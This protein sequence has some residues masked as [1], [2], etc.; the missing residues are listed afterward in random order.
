MTVKEKYA[1][2]EYEEMYSEFS[3]YLEEMFPRYYMRS[4]IVCF[5]P[6]LACCGVYNASDWYDISA[7]PGQNWVPQSCCI[8]PYMNCEKSENPND[9]HSKV[10]A[11]SLLPNLVKN[12]RNTL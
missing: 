3:K 6:Q 8:T 1:R 11:L 4:T 9:W 10:L 5:I 12:Y 2:C 7:W